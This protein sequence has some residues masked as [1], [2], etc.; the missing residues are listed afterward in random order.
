MFTLYWKYTVF[1]ELLQYNLLDIFGGGTY[2]SY[3]N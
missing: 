3:I 2:G 1:I